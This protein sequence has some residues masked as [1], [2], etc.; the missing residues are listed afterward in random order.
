MFSVYHVPP[1]DTASFTQEL[2]FSFSFF[3]VFILF[4]FPDSRERFYNYRT[5]TWQADLE[6][7][8]KKE[9]DR[10]T[11]RKVKSTFEPSKT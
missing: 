6:N 10:Q 2:I 5:H 9:T 11:H 4:A 8:E 3:K 1:V 7:E